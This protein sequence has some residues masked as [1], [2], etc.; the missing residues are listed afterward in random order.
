MHGKEIGVFC[1]R[2]SNIGSQS[3][4]FFSTLYRGKCLR[5]FIKEVEN[6]KDGNDFTGKVKEAN[7]PS[8]VAVFEVQSIVLQYASAWKTFNNS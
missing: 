3:H 8:K 7:G 5:A 4:R 1:L 6:F 2:I